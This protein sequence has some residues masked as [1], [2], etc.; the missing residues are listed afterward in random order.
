[1]H[2]N[3][4]SYKIPYTPAFGTNFIT[5]IRNE[6][7][8]IYHTITTFFRN[9]LDWDNAADFLDDKYANVQNVNVLNF[10]CSDGSEPMSLALILS[11]KLGQKANKFFPIHASDFDQTMVNRA[12]SGIYEI[13]NNDLEKI[14]LHSNNQMN[15]YFTLL[16]Q[17]NKIKATPQ[18]RTKVDFTVYDMID[19]LD[20]VKS[21]NNV[22]LCRNCLPYLHPQDRAYF[23]Y[24]LGKKLDNT[25][26]LII[27][28]MEQTLM[29]NEEFEEFGF[30][31]SGVEGIYI[32]K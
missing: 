13:T 12:N 26:C 24:I 28:N 16:P 22:I 10:A 3:S 5:G 2:I 14:K 9:D 31:K 27:G 29:A 6:R 4:I 18:F 15:K 25:G 17:K 20:Y 23:L 21:K 32:K 11:E 1:M 19:G 7:G 8:Q 30:K